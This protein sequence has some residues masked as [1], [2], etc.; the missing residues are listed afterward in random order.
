MSPAPSSSTALS[1]RLSQARQGGA[2]RRGAALDDLRRTTHNRLIDELGPELQDER[3]TPE[4]LR[5]KVRDR[6]GAALRGSSVSAADRAELMEEV[7]DDI[8][9]YGPISRYLED[10]TV[11]EVMVNGPARV[12]VERHGKIARA[13]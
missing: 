13:P 6:L 2:E 8:L 12:Y 7:A 11:T 9:G 4:E 3:L 1:K 10:D 5:F